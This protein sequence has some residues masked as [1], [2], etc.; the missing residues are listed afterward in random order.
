MWCHF[1]ITVVIYESSP[2]RKKGPFKATIRTGPKQRSLVHPEVGRRRAIVSVKNPR[3][4]NSSY[5][6]NAASLET[7]WAFTGLLFKSLYGSV[8]N[9]RPIIVTSREIML[10][11]SNTILTISIA[12]GNGGKIQSR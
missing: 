2:F 11:D 12:T 9:R 10:N 3:P 4:N 1:H 6:Q 7:L 5:Y 8:I